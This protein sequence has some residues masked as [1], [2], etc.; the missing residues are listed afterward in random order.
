MCIISFLEYLSLH[1]IISLTSGSPHVKVQVLS[2]IKS[3][4]LA[5]SSRD[6]PSLTRIPFLLRFPIA[7]IIAVGVART[8]AHG[9]NTTSTVTD[10]KI[11]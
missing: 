10:L 2:K 5:S 8:N 11:S 7:A 4:T 9:Q 1:E 3:F 6:S